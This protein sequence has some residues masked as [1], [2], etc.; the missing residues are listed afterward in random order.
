MK[1]DKMKGD[2]REI[3]EFESENVRPSGALWLNLAGI[4]L[5]LLLGLALIFY[6][7]WRLASSIGPSVPDIP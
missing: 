3:W 2:S 5:A 6:G 7:V 4:I 1:P